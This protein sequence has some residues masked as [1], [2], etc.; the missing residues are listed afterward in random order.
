MLKI[1]KIAILLIFLIFPISISAHV[2]H[3]KDLNRIEFDIYRNNKHIGKHIFSFKRQGDQFSVDS[4]INFEIKKLGIVLYKYHVSGTEHYLNGKLIKFA[5][6]TDQ[7]GKQ[8][9]VNMILIL[10]QLWKT[11]VLI[12]I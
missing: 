3:Y 10:N 7:N 5:S 8:K 9:Y 11:K 2:E 6:K 12:L 4:E 1:Y